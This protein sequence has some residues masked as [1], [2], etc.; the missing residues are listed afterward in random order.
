MRPHTIALLS[1][2]AALALA[3]SVALAAN[4]HSDTHEMTIRLADGTVEHIQYEGSVAPRIVIGSDPFAHVWPGAAAFWSVP[5]VSAL[6]RVSAEMDRRM[7]ELTRRTEALLAAPF[8]DAGAVDQA[9]RRS[10]PTG[11][12]SYS[13]ITMSTGKGVCTRTVQ[14]TASLKGEKPQVVSHSFGD[15]DSNSRSVPASVANHVSGVTPAKLPSMASGRTD[16][17]S[18]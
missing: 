9:G 12:S 13:L 4:K 1:G 11:S 15:C 6:D 16:E 3:G 7:E 10:L 18:L 17:T 8:P 5:S 2:I 14:V